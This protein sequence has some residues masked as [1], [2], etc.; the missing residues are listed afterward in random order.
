MILQTGKKWHDTTMVF[1]ACFQKVRE[2]LFV[3]EFEFYCLLQT[4][5]ERAQ[6]TSEMQIDEAPANEENFINLTTCQ[7]RNL[8]T[9]QKNPK[10]KKALKRLTTQPVR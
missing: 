7:K 1:P 9:C 8:T 10:Q 6:H 2:T 5:A 3:V 4:M